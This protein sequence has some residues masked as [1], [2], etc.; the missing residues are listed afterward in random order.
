MAL[1]LSDG[2]DENAPLGRAVIGGLIIASLF[3]L[4]VVPVL[5]ATIRKNEP[6]HEIELPDAT[7]IEQ[8]F[9]APGAEGATHG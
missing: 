5:Y 8:Q 4:I 2:G 3:T 9:A 6:L 1:A 7:P